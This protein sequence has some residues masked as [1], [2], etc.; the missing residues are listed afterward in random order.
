MDQVAESTVDWKSSI[1]DMLTVVAEFLPKLLMFVII[2]LIG[3]FIAKQIRKLVAKGL[4]KV[5]F[6]AYIDK[7]GLGAPLERAGFADSGNF[8]AKLFYYI[9]ALTTLKVAFDALGIVA[10]SE[11]LDSLIAFIPRVIVAIILVIV[12]GIIANVVGD[13][14]SAATEGQSFGHLVTK[15][16]V[17][18][19][20][21]IF[22]FAAFDE[23]GIA[24]DIVNTLFTAVVGSLSAIMIIKFGVG[25]I[26]S[27]RDRFWPNVYDSVA[28]SEQAQGD[29]Q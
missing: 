9:I 18:G 11:P 21:F 20:W 26:W 24:S 3:F 12:G 14:V 22:G 23:L 28:G 7:A 6:D 2:L 29:V 4:R 16:A 8:V 25:G 5:N 1:T 19:V 15:A 17:F 13:I 27:A 10:L